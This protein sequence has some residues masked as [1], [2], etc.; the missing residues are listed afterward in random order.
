ML[1]TRALG[2]RPACS[3]R[4]QR[5]RHTRSF[6]RTTHT[7]GSAVLRLARENPRWGYQRSGELRALG[8]RIAG[9]TVRKLLKPG[10][11]RACR[12]ALR[13]SWRDLPPCAGTQHARGRLLHG[14]D[15]LSETAV[16]ALLHRARESTVHLAGCTA[17]PSGALLTQQ[18]RQLAWTLAE[19]STPVRFLIRD[20]DRDREFTASSAAKRSRSSARRSK[21]PNRTPSPNAS[22][23]PSAWMSRLAPDPQPPTSRASVPRLRRPLQRPHRALNLTPPDPT[24]PT[25]RLAGSS[26]RDHVERRDRLGGLIHEYSLAA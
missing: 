4:R 22:S 15:R 17:S 5:A 2:R 3:S 6:R 23:A 20:R 13:L 18:A 21:H 26:A 25:L 8:L 19:L 12:R 7:E 14:R 1:G 10:W 16:R 24:R 9:T 11:P